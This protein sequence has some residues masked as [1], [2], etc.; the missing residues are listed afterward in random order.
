[1]TKT[2]RPKTTKPDFQPMAVE[3]DIHEESIVG[4]FATPTGLPGIGPLWISRSSWDEVVP[5]P[6]VRP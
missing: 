3:F 1:M 2:L 6:A 5:V 4:W